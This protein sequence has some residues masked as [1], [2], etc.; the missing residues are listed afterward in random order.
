MRGW[1]LEEVQRVGH[2]EVEHVGDAPALVAHLE[3]LAIVAPALAHLARHVDVGQEVHLDLHQPVALARLAAAALHVEGEPARAVAAH[4]GLGQLGEQLADRGEQPGVGRRVGARRAA[5]G[6]LVDVD[7]LVDLL[8]PLDPGVRAGHDLGAVEV[9]RQRLV[10]DVGDQRGL[11]RAGHARHGH[12]EPE[13]DVDRE[14]PQ[15]VR[16]GAD[17]PQP[18]L[19]RRLAAG[20][21]APGSGA[22]RG[23]SGR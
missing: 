16:P 19:A 18:V 4:L 17:D 20:P 3:R 23:G 6:A 22:R 15:V 10:Q 11:A 21:A 9:P 5:D 8:E 13:R 7:D 2:G 12:E 1:L 14:V